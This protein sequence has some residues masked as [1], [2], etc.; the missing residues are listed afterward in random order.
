MRRWRKL[1]LDVMSLVQSAA[2]FM[3]LDAMA[4]DSLLLVHLPLNI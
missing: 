2:V 4:R 1:K 3:T